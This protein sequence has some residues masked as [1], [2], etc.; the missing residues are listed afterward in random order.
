MIDHPPS[1]PTPIAGLLLTGGASSR[2]GQNKALLDIG[3]KKLIERVVQALSVVTDAILIVA[4]DAEP[5]R[6]L[7]L[8]VI[9]D[10]EKGYGPLMG[11]YSGLKAVRSELA[12][13]AAVDMPFLSPDFLRY[14]LALALD[15]DVVVPNAYDRLHP[16][17]AVYRRA[18][19]L[20]AI[21][22]TIARGQR[23]LIAF[24]SQVRVRKVSEAEMR[25]IDPDLRTL[26]NVNTP[27]DLT[28]A[29]ALLGG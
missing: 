1:S 9:P 2:M 21:E 10:I 23:R 14:L 25:R 7:N 11:L 6:F 12:V 15:Y 4:N 3:G 19:C 29:R 26:M 20:P 8:P 27:E 17:C 13:L 24:H 18:S 28:R 22:Q 16:L 5:Y